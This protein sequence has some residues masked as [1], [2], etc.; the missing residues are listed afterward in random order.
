MS[1]LLLLARCGFPER[2]IQ[3][4]CIY[5]AQQGASLSNREEGVGR[6]QT[7]PPH[8]DRPEF[9]V[10]GIVKEDARLSPRLVLSYKLKGATRQGMKRVGD[11]KGLCIVQVIGC[12]WPLI[13]R[14]KYRAR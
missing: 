10:R 11:S 12:S 9:L 5:Q 14:A 4:L 8:R 7:G 13:R 1:I 3:A 6:S 2:F